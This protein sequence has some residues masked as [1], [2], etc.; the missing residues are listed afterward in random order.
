ME[1]LADCEISPWMFDIREL[2]DLKLM[3]RAAAAASYE[4][5]YDLARALRER[6]ARD[7]ARKCA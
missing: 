4:L 3:K 7:Q 5:D 1:G 2:H 6:S